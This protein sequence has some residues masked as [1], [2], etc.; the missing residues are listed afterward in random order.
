MGA[1]RFVPLLLATALAAGAC[2][3]RQSDTP[4]APSLA[5]GGGSGGGACNFT[6]ISG[7]V[8]DEFGANSP[9]ASLAGDMKNAG[10][11]TDQATYDGYLLLQAVS[12][13]YESVAPT[14]STPSTLAA[15][16]LGCM[17]TGGATI[18][19]AAT[20]AKALAADGAFEVRGLVKPDNQLVASHDAA[21]VLEPPA[22]ACWQSTVGGDCSTTGTAGGF[23]A[24]T[25]P[26]IQYAFLAYGFPVSSTDFTNDSPVSGVFD[27]STLPTAT[28]SAPG[29][30]VGEC[31]KPSNYLQ[32]LPASNSSVEVLGLIQPS[33]PT[34]TTGMTRES[35][36]RTLAERLIR[37]L[38][39]EPAYAAL[40]T[41]TGTGGSKRTLSP[42]S[43]VFP[44]LVVLDPQFKWS[45]SGN[46]VNVPLSPTPVYQI[47]SSAGTPFK[48]D[49]V[50]LWLTATNN[51]GV[52]VLMCNNWAYTN[53]TGVA[54]F[55]NAFLNKSGGY[56]VTTYSA[57]ATDL[58]AIV[59]LPQVPP[60]TPVVSPLFN[61][62]NGSG[63]PSCLTFSPIFDSNGVLT[64]PPDYPGPNP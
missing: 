2:S 34:G 11:Q 44:G 60:S 24:S 46:Q 43:V 56:T 58:T 22:A 59:Q 19:T 53:A 38:S 37:A 52:N 49:K 62:K 13:K 28:F 26:R 41:S 40:L 45:K 16:L 4:T 20:F 1:H 42:F 23:G 57:G 64:N 17:K 14:T 31:T 9:E 36:A 39:P 50:L 27:W 3:D 7:L 30:V 12:T 5:R 25:D 54:T 8:K 35:P 6:T 21:W 51:S 61:V 15:A 32:H 47:R 18:P 29:V 10:D 55:T 33:C 48:Q 63:N